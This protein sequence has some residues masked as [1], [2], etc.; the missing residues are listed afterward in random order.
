M[1]VPFGCSTLHVLKRVFPYV[2]WCDQNENTACR[3]RVGNL[4]F[5]TTAWVRVFSTMQMRRSQHNQ[6]ARKQSTAL[7][8]GNIAAVSL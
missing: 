2:H 8:N 4:D 7:L 6:E 5:D 1:H 3:I